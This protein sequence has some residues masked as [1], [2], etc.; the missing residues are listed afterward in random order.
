MEKIN[1]SEYTNIK[2]I[3]PNVD[4]NDLLIIS[5]VLITDYSSV[6]Y[7]FLLTLRPIIFFAEDLE[8]YMEVRDFYFDYKTFVPG[9]YVQTGDQLLEK[10]QTIDQWDIEYQEKRRQ[11]RDRFNKYIDGKATVR[12]IELLN[13]KVF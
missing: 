1:L 5:N 7:D 2:S 12:I 3:G 11:T 10:L 9:P 8:K 13:L 6:F 4:I